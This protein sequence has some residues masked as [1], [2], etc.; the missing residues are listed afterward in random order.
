VLYCWSNPP[1]ENS[2]SVSLAF[3]HDN[4]SNFTT[5]SPNPKNLELFHDRAANDPNK[6]LRRWAEEQLKMQNV[7]LK[8][9]DM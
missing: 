1:N 7:K 6:R 5:V 3:K 2:A 9:E 4:Q 8:L